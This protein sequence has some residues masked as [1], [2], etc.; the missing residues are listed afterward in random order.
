MRVKGLTLCL[1]FTS[2]PRYGSNCETTVIDS[3]G[4]VIQAPSPT[5]VPPHALRKE[6]YCP[7]THRDPSPGSLARGCPFHINNQKSSKMTEAPIWRSPSFH[8][9]ELK[10]QLA[11]DPQKLWFFLQEFS[12]Q[13]RHPVH[14]PSSW[15]RVNKA[16][17]LEQGRL[18]LSASLSR[19]HND[20]L[21]LLWNIWIQKRKLGTSHDFMEVSW[22]DLLLPPQMGKLNIYCFMNPLSQLTLPPKLPIY[23]VLRYNHSLYV[24]QDLV[25]VQ[26]I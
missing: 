15:P 17:L 7:S 5:L 20:F 26:I 6:V 10:S 23:W 16:L 25:Q 3:C 14:P 2:C 12:R 24:F 18:S 4:S 9:E 22:L 8:S 11:S 21:H 1:T 13:I 19:W